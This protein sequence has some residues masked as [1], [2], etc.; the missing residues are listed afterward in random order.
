MKK[1]VI[2]ITVVVIGLIAVTA[3]KLASNKAK[4]EQKIYI[5]DINAAVLVEAEQPQMHTFDNS[6]S[7]LGTFEPIRQNVI[8][9]D[10]SGKV[11]QLNVEEG[12]YV[13]KGQVIAK[14]DDELLQ[15]QLQNVEV[16]IEGQRND[17]KRYSTL[18]KV[19]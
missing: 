2:I 13:T 8:G 12:D 18:I 11:I 1:R 3:M 6:F 14:V 10:A 9:S 16:N 19:E 4:V 7:Y 15:Y 17:D 5:H